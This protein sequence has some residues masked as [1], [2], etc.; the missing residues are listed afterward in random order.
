MAVNLSALRAGRPLPP[1]RFLLLISVR[2]SVNLRAEAQLE[3]LWQF[4]TKFNDFIAQK[5]C[6]IFSQSIMLQPSPV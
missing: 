5:N 1:G 6:N 4:I 2:D 3:E